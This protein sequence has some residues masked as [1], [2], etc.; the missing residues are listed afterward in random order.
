MTGRK[1]VLI[2]PVNRLRTGLSVNRS[3]RFPPLS[4]GMVAALTPA[5]WEMELVDEN[6]EPFTYRDADLVG[7][8]AFTSSANRAYEIAALYK[9]QGVPVVMGGIHASMCPNEALRFVDAVIIGEAESVWTDVLE[10][11]LSGTLR[12]LYRGDRQRLINLKQ[13]RRD[14]YHDQY[15]F[16]SM[17]TS[18]GCPLDCD[19]CSVSEFNGRRYRRRPPAQVLDELDTIP[20]ESIFFVDDNII[21]YGQQDR[22]Q[23]LQM[24]KGMVERGMNKQWFCQASVNIADD[25]EV[26]AWASRAG[27]RMIF[28]GIEA[29]DIDALADV[30]KRLNLRRGT[31]A[32][33]RT[34]E[35][36][37]E[38][39]IAVLGAFIFGM[40]SDTPE[41]LY[42]RADYMINSGVDVM[43]ATALTPLPGTRLFRKMKEEG[44]LL[45]TSF[46]QDWDRYNMT[47]VVYQPK[48]MEPDEFS[49]IM[50]ECLRQ[51]FDL[52]VLKAKAKRTLKATGRSDTMAFA[53]QANIDY[54]N[55]AMADSTFAGDPLLEC[56]RDGPHTAIRECLQ[57]FMPDR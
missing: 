48:R 3:S 50:R 57:T 17:Q 5:T 39:G 53:W 9:Q 11:A 18:R 35:R 6:I 34:F 37:H 36:I 45:Y 10:D 29:E 16:A 4:L 51:I 22:E 52:R 15:L 25:Q 43:Q 13:V 12:S 54:R 30:N 32:Y 42:R 40:D 49:Q 47:E 19:F 38:A 24:F 31:S 46:P 27:C 55:I 26:L 14:I 21:G 41:K 33:A 2:N 23:A 44:R 20:Q 28:L 1:L 56:G 7:I 8:T